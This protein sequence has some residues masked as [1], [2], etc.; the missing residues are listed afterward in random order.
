MSYVVLDTDAMSQSIKERLPANLQARLAGLST[1]I[2]FVTYGELTQWSVIRDW[3]LGRREA[4]ALRLAGVPVL[5]GN[6]DVARIWGEI[7]A[8]ARRRGRTGP[9]ND[10]WIAA[11]CLHYGLPLATL[12]VKDFQHFADHEHLT[13]IT[14]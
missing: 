5:H 9:Q 3:G 11:C 8:R 13:L 6:T 4:L 7:A 2:T 1:C 10:T 12:N 14:A